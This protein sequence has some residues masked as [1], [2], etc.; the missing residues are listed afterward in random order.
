MVFSSIPFLFYFLPV[1]LICYL[2]IGRNVFLRNLVFLLFSLFFYAWGEAIFVLVMIGSIVGNYAFGL[3]IGYRRSRTILALGIAFNLALLFWFKYAAFLVENLTGFGAALGLGR[4]VTVDVH[5]P[6]GISFFTF[7]A[8]SYL[9]DVYRSQAT[10]ERSFSTLALFISMFPQLI[11]GPIVR[12]QSIQTQLHDR[13]LS[14]DAAYRGAQLF[15]VGLAQ[16]VLIADTLAFPADRIFALPVDQL[17]TGLAWFGAACYTL[18]IYFDFAGYSTM[19]IG[20]GLIAGFRLPKNFDYPYI[21]Q[22]VTE[23][24]RRWHMTLSRWFR[25]YLYIPLG[26]NREGQRRTYR[27]LL[28]VFVL[29]GLWHGAAWNF[30]VWGLWHGGFLVLERVGLGRRIGTLW[31]PIGHAYLLLVVVIGWVVFRANDL[32]HAGAYLLQMSGLGA[33]SDA[34]GRLAEFVWRDT[35]L[36]AVLAV[37]AILS[38][39]LPARLFGYRDMENASAF[40]AQPFVKR[41]LVYG[42]GPILAL[43][44]V[45][46]MLGQSYSPFIYFRF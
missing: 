11:A 15:V 28:I 25:D 20:L 46:A 37:G 34:A 6:I 35:Y 17:G 22:S 23:F 3:I 38:T 16:K 1:F 31:Q 43:I 8:L 5:L 12:F 29:C 2:L 44:V 32:P 27:N 4:P 40:E 13:S 18:Q 36:L 10:A 30:L 41:S 14:I 19:A 39:P 45:I 26:G 21:A 42:I 7:Q 9:I 24:W 33:G